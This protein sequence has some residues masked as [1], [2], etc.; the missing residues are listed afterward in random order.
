MDKSNT[1]SLECLTPGS[2]VWGAAFELVYEKCGIR[3]MKGGWRK[4]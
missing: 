3:S 1:D 2:L 4:K